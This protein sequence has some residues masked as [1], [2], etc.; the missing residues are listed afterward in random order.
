[1][2][3]LSIVIP[4]YNR[5][6]SLARL[7]STLLEQDHADHKVEIV[8][9]LDG[10]IDGSAETLA[11]VVVPPGM[12]LLIRQ[13]PNRGPSA[14]RN[15]GIADASGEIV[16][17]LDDDMVPLPRFVKSHL[18]AYRD[19]QIDGVIGQI[20]SVSAPCVPP[21]VATLMENLFD[22]QHH[23]LSE[24]GAAVTAM[25]VFT[26]NLSVKRSRLLEVGGFDESLTGLAAEDT[27]LGHR[28]LAAGARFVY[29][30]DAVADHYCTFE[31][32]E[33]RHRVWQEGAAD[34]RLSRLRPAIASYLTIDSLNEG[35]VGRRIAAQ[36]AIQFPRLALAAS[37]VPF[38]IMPVASRIGGPHP[39]LALTHLS[40]CLA[41]WSG[42]SRTLGSARASRAGRS[43]PVPILAYHRLCDR[44]EPALAKYAVAP[45]QFARH[46]RLLHRLGFRTVTLRELVAAFEAGIPI[47]KKTVVLTFDD[48]YLDTVQ[49]AAPILRS[50]GYRAT[51]FAVAGCVGRTAEWDAGSGISATP[52]ATWEQL[53]ALR[54]AGWEVGFHTVT[55]PDLTTLPLDRLNAE[56]VEG[57]A[58]FQRALG[59]PVETLAY[60]YGS[61]SPRVVSVARRSGAR[62]AVEATNDALK[63][64]M[65]TRRWPRYTL[66]RR[67]VLRSD[68]LLDIFLL[69]TTG[70]RVPGRVRHVFTYPQAVL[71]FAERLVGRDRTGTHGSPKSRVGPLPE[72]VE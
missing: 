12:T 35:K 71:G 54:D 66:P 3:T 72:A 20:K 67:V 57:L 63:S 2:T 58:A 62:A 15:A 29:V 6:E 55:H 41:Y 28:L 65:A 11:E 64:A 17:F 31:S 60:P 69:V 19:V 14:A 68:R 48:G 46:M 45:A 47:P 26:G 18:E 70:N 39:A 5:R 10:S 1:M 27:D 56:I 43:Y 16:L 7:V 36:F 9:V 38:G 42:V 61:H 51:V 33:W 21:T 52:L 8:V 50:Y 23:R 59:S 32:Q 44:P 25:D 22:D 40:H 24:E 4:S 30:P 37:A 53:R 13:Q 34:A 49:V